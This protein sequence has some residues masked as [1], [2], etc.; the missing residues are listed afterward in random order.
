VGTRVQAAD[1]APSDPILADP[2]EAY[3][4]EVKQALKEAMLDY[5]GP[6]G[7]RPQ[8]WLTIAARRDEE[9]SESSGP[10]KAARPDT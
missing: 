3:R 6:L 7:I 10:A 8:E 2:D 4:A 1:L 5:G 9:D